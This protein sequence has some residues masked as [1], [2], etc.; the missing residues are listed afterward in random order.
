MSEELIARPKVGI[1]FTAYNCVEYTQNAVNSIRTSFPFQLIVIDDFSTDGTK[2]WLRDLTLS[3]NN[4]WIN[5]NE[6]LCEGLSTL[7]DVPTESLGE[8]W[9][10]GVAEASKQGCP[11]ALICNNDILFHPA[12]I[13]TL[14]NRWIKSKTDQEKLAIVSAHNRRGDTKPED[15][16]T[17]A[18]PEVPSEAESPDFSAFLLDIEAWKTVGKFDINYVPC[19]FE[20]NDTVCNLAQ[21]DYLAIT[22]TAA[23]YYHFGS[24]TQN[25]VPGGLCKSPQFERNRDYFRAKWG[26]IPGEPLYDEIAHRRVKVSPVVV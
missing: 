25:S 8:K 22:T 11:I 18:V 7:I 12:T 19:Y 21:H 1:I 20:D 2:K 14:V 3:Y 17:L 26:C 24:I 6:G 10:L 15:I 23:P 9:N 4:H 13:D 5:Y 16:F